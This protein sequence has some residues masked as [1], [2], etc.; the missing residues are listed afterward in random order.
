MT[1]LPTYDMYLKT[2]EFITAEEY[3]ERRKRGEID[4]TDVRIVPADITTGSMGG[5]IVKLKTPEYAPTLP[6][7]K[8]PSYGW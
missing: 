7:K 5:F 3:L 2:E 8:E 6:K 4:S 1:T